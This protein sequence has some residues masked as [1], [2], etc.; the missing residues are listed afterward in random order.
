M[1]TLRTA[2]RDP[3]LLH[4]AG[5]VL[6]LARGSTEPRISDPSVQ[7]PEDR[8]AAAASTELNRP[9]PMDAVV[10]THFEIEAREDMQRLIGI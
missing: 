4:A 8:N 1:R 9:D 3:S 10:T 5:R 7:L 2:R 6:L